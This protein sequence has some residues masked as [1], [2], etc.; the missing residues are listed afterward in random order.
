V[1]VA[2]LAEHLTVDQIA[3][4]SNSIKHPVNVG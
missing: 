4:G 2:Q 1:P 3:K